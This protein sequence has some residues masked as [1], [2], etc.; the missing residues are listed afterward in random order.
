MVVAT[1][2]NLSLSNLLDGKAL[3]IDGL[4]NNMI[5]FT[6]EHFAVGLRLPIP[7]LV[8]QFLHFS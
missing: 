4:P 5:Y 3:F 6:K 2:H 7:S 8:K 1:S